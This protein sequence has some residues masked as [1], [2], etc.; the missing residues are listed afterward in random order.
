MVIGRIATIR[1]Y[2]VK[3]PPHYATGFLLLD[4][5]LNGLTCQQQRLLKPLQQ[6]CDLE[7]SLHRGYQ[8]S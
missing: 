6:R 8:A 1:P 4:F 7:R 2:K 3:N 5:L